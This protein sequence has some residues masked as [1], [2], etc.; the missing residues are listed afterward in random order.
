MLQNLFDKIDLVTI[1]VA[2][3]GLVSILWNSMNSKRAQILAVR[4]KINLDFTTKKINENNIEAYLTIENLGSKELI[5]RSFRIYGYDIGFDESMYFGLS[6]YSDN[7][8]IANNKILNKYHNIELS[9]EYDNFVES[10]AKILNKNVKDIK[11]ELDSDQ[12]DEIIMFYEKIQL[13]YKQKYNLVPALLVRS[14]FVLESNK[15]FLLSL[16]YISEDILPATVQVIL[17]DQ[18]SYDKSK[19]KKDIFARFS[20]NFRIN[21]EF[22][23]I[24]NLENSPELLEIESNFKWV[25]NKFLKKELQ[26]LIAVTPK[27]LGFVSQLA[28]GEKRTTNILIPILNGKEFKIQLTLYFSTSKPNFMILEKEF[29]TF[30][31]A[32]SLS[33]LK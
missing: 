8:I 30:I 26:P 11:Q 24:W 19:I 31:T 21:W 12:F 14:F 28:S 10:I 33:S 2:L 5:L 29:T 7:I 27:E 23:P 4:P 9:F 25:K 18:A 15:K 13:I 3:P 16:S 20:D 6:V 17:F 22:N 32:F 1:V